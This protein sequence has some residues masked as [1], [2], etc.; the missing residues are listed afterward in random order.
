[1]KSLLTAAA[2]AVALVPAGLT[3]QA[4]AGAMPAPSTSPVADAFRRMEA[5]AAR[6]L[7]AAAETMPADKYGYKPTPA[8]MSFKAVVVHL[9]EGND[10]LCSVAAGSKA[11]ERAKVDTATATKEQLI[12]RLKETFQFCET[13]LASLDDSKLNEMLPFFGGRS[14][15]RASVL[16]ITVGD[17]ADHYSQWANYLRLNG[18]LPPTARANNM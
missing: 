7:T 5:R 4:A 8:Q 15:S 11:P 2:V 14:V 9:Y 13:T 3:A 18:L 6:D 10:Y 12:A 1:M 16:F 17:W